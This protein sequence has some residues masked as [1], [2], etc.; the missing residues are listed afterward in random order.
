MLKTKTYA[1]LI[2]IITNPCHSRY[3]NN[4]KYIHIYKSKSLQLKGQ[5]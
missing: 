5:P 3:Y 1:Y 2:I 4:W